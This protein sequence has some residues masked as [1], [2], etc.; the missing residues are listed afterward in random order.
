[1]LRRFS[2]GWMISGCPADWKLAAT[3]AR[4][5][6]TACQGARSWIARRSRM[7][8]KSACIEKSR[9]LGGKLIVMLS[10]EQPECDSHYVATCRKNT[11]RHASPFP[12]RRWLPHL[13]P[14]LL[15][16]RPC[17]QLFVIGLLG[18]G[19]QGLIHVNMPLHSAI[20][21]SK[22]R[23]HQRIEHGS[24]L[25]VFCRLSLSVLFRC[26]LWGDEGL[27]PVFAHNVASREP[28]VTTLEGPTRSKLTLGAG[29]KS[30]WD[31][32][33]R[34]RAPASRRLYVTFCS[35]GGLQNGDR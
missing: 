22:G 20:K 21:V 1:M 4:A 24:P 6:V 23:V 19:S 11:D 15:D 8:L 33:E 12:R 34:T 3:I 9:S 7:A 31:V 14:L 30:F 18:A 25:I 13:I 27:V 32:V 35:G 10:S 17:A 5:K 26:Q 2:V 16:F 28:M 29:V